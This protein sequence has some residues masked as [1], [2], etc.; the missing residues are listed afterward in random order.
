MNINKV[1]NKRTIILTSLALFLFTGCFGDRDPEQW[2]SIVYPDKENTKRS[3]K[4]GIYP[5]LE[6]CRKASLSELSNLKLE[7]KGTYQ[8]GLNCSYHEG[9]KLDICEKTMK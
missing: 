7:D 1:L 6:E 9:M 3:K 2:T 5:T 4:F 8:C